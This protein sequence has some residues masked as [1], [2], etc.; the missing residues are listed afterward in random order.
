MNTLKHYLYDISQIN[1]YF[2]EDHSKIILETDGNGIFGSLSNM[3]TFPKILSNIE[4]DN[5]YYELIY[6]NRSTY[7]GQ[8]KIGKEQQLLMHGNGI[9][10]L[11]SGFQLN[12]NWHRNMFNNGNIICKIQQIRGY[13]IKLNKYTSKYILQDRDI[14]K[15]LFVISGDISKE[16]NAS[17]IQL[18]LENSECILELKEILK[19]M[20]IN[21]PIL[22]TPV[23]EILL[24]SRPSRK[25]KRETQDNI[26]TQDNKK[27]K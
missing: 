16:S 15:T 1:T 14:E 24:F 18:V 12:G 21:V 8:V 7:I 4:I 25:S 19:N 2:E 26:D 5:G 13:R 23:Q 10:S 20:V 3:L 17:N 6:D 22:Q 11:A 27:S 9:L